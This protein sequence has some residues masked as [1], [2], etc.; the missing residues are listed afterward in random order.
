MFSEY[1]GIPF[2]HGGRDREGID[3][4]GLVVLLYKEK[5]NINLFDVEGYSEDSVGE[6]NYFITNY[7]K[8][9][10]RIDPNSLQ[11]FDV[12]LFYLDELVPTHIGVFIENDKFIHCLS[13]NVPVSLGKLN[14]RLWKSKFHSAYRYKGEV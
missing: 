9:W 6:E 4:Y 7:H 12:L 10:E 2:K 3:C 14:S 11:L 1:L 13:E 5:R 8:E